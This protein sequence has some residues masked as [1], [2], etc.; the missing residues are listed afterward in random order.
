M[1]EFN[2]NKRQI[3]RLIIR[4]STVRED[5]R[6]DNDHEFDQQFQFNIASIEGILLFP[7][8]SERLI[9]R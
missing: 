6:E 8:L 2:E 3:K 9:N 1:V 7:F 4:L 5:S